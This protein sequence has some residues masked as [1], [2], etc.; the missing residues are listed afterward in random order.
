MK[1]DLA[2][3][4][5]LGLLDGFQNPLLFIRGE[6]LL[7]IVPPSHVSPDSL[8]YE[9]GATSFRWR[10][11]RQTH[12]RRR[13]NRRL[14]IRFCPWR[15]RD[16]SFRR[17]WQG[18]SPNIRAAACGNRRN[19]RTATRANRKYPRPPREKPPALPPF[20]PRLALIFALC[21]RDNAPQPCD[22]TAVVISLAKPGRD[23]IADD[24]AGQRVRQSPFQPI[25]HF[26]SKPSI[27]P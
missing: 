22:N 10:H 9:M 18:P 12:R 25:S 23:L 24:C 11:P 13:R 4:M 5:I 1:P 8:R 26:N 7:W 19:R 2:R 21:R 15:S 16:G 27:R 17:I 6:E 20:R 3:G 14:R